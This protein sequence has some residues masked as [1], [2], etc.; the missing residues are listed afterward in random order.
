MKM[1]DIKPVCALSLHVKGQCSQ[2]CEKVLEGRAP[3]SSA[4]YTY[5]VSISV[6]VT[7]FSVIIICVE[8]VERWRLLRRD[9]SRLLLCDLQPGMHVRT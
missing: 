4:M 8:Y 9:L 7:F 5:Q 2:V 3:A 6:S 1:E